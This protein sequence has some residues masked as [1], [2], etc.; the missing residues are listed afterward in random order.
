[1]SILDDED[2]VIQGLSNSSMSKIY[3]PNEQRGELS[4][5]V[6]AEWANVYAHV[7]TSYVKFFIK[8]WNKNDVNETNKLMN[9]ELERVGI[10][11][12]IGLTAEENNPLGKYV[13][14]LDCPVSAADMREF[15]KR[16]VKGDLE[17]RCRYPIN[18]TNALELIKTLNLVF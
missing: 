14:S 2:V 5:I 15:F 13:L 18:D 11:G 6:Y 16:V 3:I 12:W 4:P 17:F 10:H 9:E 8:C 1:M 7:M